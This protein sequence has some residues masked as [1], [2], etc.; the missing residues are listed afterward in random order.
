MKNPEN[1]ENKITSMEEEV[2]EHAPPLTKSSLYNK[3]EDLQREE[4]EKV[5]EIERKVDEYVNEY[6]R[7]LY[8]ESSI[9]EITEEWRNTI[10]QAEQET[11]ENLRRFIHEAY[12]GKYG[13]GTLAFYEDNIKRISRLL[14]I[15]EISQP[16]EQGDPSS[17]PLSKE[18]KNISEQKGVRGQ[19][20]L[21]EDRLDSQ[22]INTSL[23]SLFA[24]VSLEGTTNDDYK[25]L[26]RDMT[27]M[28]TPDN[29]SKRVHNLFYTMSLFPDSFKP[30]V[31]AGEIFRFGG[32]GHHSGDIEGLALVLPTG[33]L[34]IVSK[35]TGEKE[36]L[37]D[38]LEN[39]DESSGAYKKQYLWGAISDPHW[40]PSWSAKNGELRNADDLEPLTSE[41][42][43]FLRHREESQTENKSHIIGK[44]NPKKEL[45]P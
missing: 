9:K 36:Y 5:T 32:S 7:K 33:R 15:I 8:A 38:V 25:R 4:R 37:A 30:D 28:P 43:A 42:I 22:D 13:R 2:H 20:L 29:P 21:Q 41:E 24:E 26:F 31:T 19:F 34:A 3:A 40:Q 39:I 27:S 35:Y 44:S 23:G 6:R 14:R 17:S 1:L 11:K 12:D 18:R 45:N 10:H 16:V